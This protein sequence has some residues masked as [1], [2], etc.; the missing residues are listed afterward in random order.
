MTMPLSLVISVGGERERGG[1]IDDRLNWRLAP[2]ILQDT[3][4]KEKI[5]NALK[6]LNWS[7]TDSR[8]MKW[9]A[10]KAVIRGQCNGLSCGVRNSLQTELTH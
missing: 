3:E 6:D 2:G 5:S 10:M 1:R 7:S 9:E 4:G 8:A